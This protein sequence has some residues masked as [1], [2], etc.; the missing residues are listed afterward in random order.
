[1]LFINIIKVYKWF[2]CHMIQPLLAQNALHCDM[3]S[4]SK[5]PYVK[6]LNSKRTMSRNNPG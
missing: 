4:E 6:E 1:M 3:V 2:I 5:L